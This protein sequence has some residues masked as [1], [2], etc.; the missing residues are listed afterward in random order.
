[1]LHL[2]PFAALHPLQFL[3]SMGP[4]TGHKGELLIDHLD[5]AVRCGWAGR[6]VQ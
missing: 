1:M 2:C 3:L 5:E 6:Q 4:F